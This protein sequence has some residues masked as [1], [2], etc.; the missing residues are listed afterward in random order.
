MPELSK[1]ED[2]IE[3]SNPSLSSQV[4]SGNHSGAVAPRVAD[5]SLAA[6]LLPKG[7]LQGPRT[8]S[9]SGPSAGLVVGQVIEVHAW[10]AWHR[11]R[12]IE[13]GE[14]R[15]AWVLESPERWF[16]PEAL[17]YAGAEPYGALGEGWRLPAVERFR[18]R[19]FRSEGIDGWVGQVYDGDRP[20][21]RV[22]ASSETGALAA[23]DGEILWR[24]R[25]AEPDRDLTPEVAVNWGD[26]P[27]VAFRSVAVSA[28]DDGELLQVIRREVS[29]A[30]LALLPQLESEWERFSEC[31]E[32]D[33][34][35]IAEAKGLHDAQLCAIA[36]AIGGV[37]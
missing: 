19:V 7:G 36:A 22:E 29:A 24:Q 13:L 35:A 37:L 20:V 23:V 2:C 11:A 3:G 26:D 30:L 27:E 12:V 21:F 31:P 17:L 15:F 25:H 9:G 18:G 1:K 8:A 10:G 28:P 32:V 16:G 4:T 34:V 33:P 6:K 5:P 14:V